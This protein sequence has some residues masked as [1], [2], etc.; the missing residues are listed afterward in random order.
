MGKLKL[1]EILTS[2]V[3][4]SEERRAV[5]SVCRF[6]KENPSTIAQ[7]SE[8]ACESKLFGSSP[9][10]ANYVNYAIGVLERNGIIESNSLGIYSVK[11][12]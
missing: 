10:H 3:L 11:R 6:L 9:Y 4:S 7:V 8:Y 1:H 5:D 2:L 12:S